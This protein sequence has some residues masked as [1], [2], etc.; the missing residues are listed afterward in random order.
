MNSNEYFDL[1]V[2]VTKLDSNM[3]IFKFNQ[4]L[5]IIYNLF[6]N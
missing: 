6:Y 4:S 1:A 2:L 3:F 5:K